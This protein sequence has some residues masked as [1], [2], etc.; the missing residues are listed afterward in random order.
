MA[1]VGYLIGAGASAE[2]IPVVKNMAKDVIMTHDILKQKW[3]PIDIPSINHAGYYSHVA[4]LEIEK[5]L[6]NLADVCAYHS[7]IDTFAKKL[8]VSGKISELGVL[9]NQLSFYFTV[10]QILNPPDKRYDN[11]WASVLDN[12]NPPSKIK[13]LSWNYDFQFEKSYMDFSGIGSMNDVWKCL[14]ISSPTNLTS[15]IKPNEFH[16]TK[17]NG[18]ARFKDEHNQES[19]YFCDFGD[20]DL[21]NNLNDFLFSYF[22]LNNSVNELKFAWEN[23]GRFD[24]MNSIKP[25]LN[26]INTLVIIGYSFPFFNRKIDIDLLENM[27]SLSKIIIQDKKPDGIEERLLEFLPQ[28]EIV[29]ER[30]YDIDQ[31]V[32]PK[33]LEL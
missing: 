9:K 24:F 14:K 28:E 23:E 27:T 17:L 19:K 22:N 26:K 3:K 32:F 16:F 7:S 1:E 25:V 4:E 13:I 18:S 33:E 31:F 5:I 15:P 20:L 6:L 10:K 11:F 29:I 21:Q 8:Y 30:R 2:C 12:L